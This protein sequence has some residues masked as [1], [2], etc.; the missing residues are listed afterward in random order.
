MA[1][2]LPPLPVSAVQGQTPD[3]LI[4]RLGLQPCTT[5]DR[6][7]LQPST[8]VG[9]VSPSSA[10][11]TLCG[12]Y[13][14]N[15]ARLPRSGFRLASSSFTVN[16]SIS[17]AIFTGPGISGF[18]FINNQ[19]V[20]CGI[21]LPL[22]QLINTTVPWNTHVTMCTISTLLSCNVPVLQDDQ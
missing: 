11:F 20:K 7:G 13:L 8:T 16:S 6:L 14:N 9:H 15:T 22:Q 2:K 5:N 1:A 19:W 21:P 3:N 12:V 4:D 10:V 18:N 17:L